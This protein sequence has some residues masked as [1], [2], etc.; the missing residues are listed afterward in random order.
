MAIPMLGSVGAIVMVATMSTSGSGAPSTTR[1]LL[2]G[3]MFLFA[4]LGFV[5]VQID[6]QRRTRHQQVNGSRTEY[7]HYLSGVREVTRD[8]A[9]QQR[10]ALTWH[11]PAPRALPALAEERSRVWELTPGDEH[12]LQVRYGVCAQPL[13]LELVP[14]ETKPVEQLDPTAASAL[15]RLL[16]VHSSQADLPA[17][18]DL[19]DFDRIEITGEHD[20][21][22][23]AARALICSAASFHSPEHLVVAVLTHERHLPA[24]DWLKW[25]P[26]ALSDRQS[27]AVGPRRMVTTSLD[28]LGRLLPD[29]LG[30]RPR[31]GAEEGVALPTC[32]W[33]STAS[34]CPWA[35]TSSRR[36]GCTG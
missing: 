19:R 35:T 1:L 4:A 22:R 25:L 20:A 16:A 15:H 32:C 13:S 36:T 30:E 17:R 10:A 29:E 28:A 31:F 6:R 18:V 11:H 33:C 34:H 24:W 27:D 21:G 9:A 23:S 5:A 12:F 8:A 2:T 3:G 14:P 7:L 26:H